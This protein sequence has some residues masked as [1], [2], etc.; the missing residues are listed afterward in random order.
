MTLEFP[1]LDL[2]GGAI[3]V[4]LTLLVFSS[5]FGDHFLVRLIFYGYVGI[6]AGFSV[7]ITFNSVIFPLLF[8]PILEEPIDG[9]VQVAIPL[10]LCG[11]LVFKVSTRF[12]WVGNLSLAFL[13]GAGL[14]ALVGGAIRGTLMPQISAVISPFDL[15]RSS[16]PPEERL[17]SLVQGFVI[18]L[19]T[20]TTLTYFHF[21][22]RPRASGPLRRQEW[23]ETL[24]WIGQFFIAFALGLIFAG[25]LKAGMVALV[26]R[27]QALLNFVITLQRGF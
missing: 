8:Q 13:V 5:L 26:E 12:S 25:L 7:V 4:L 17:P 15:E 23:I 16:L 21:G 27:V 20:V 14:A 1:F 18:L 9:M 2:L 3:G 6:M 24:S 11:L 10:L 22:A 19:G